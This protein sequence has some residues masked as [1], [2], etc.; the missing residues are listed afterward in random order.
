MYTVNVAIGLMVSWHL[1]CIV[2]T[3]RTAKMTK[4][5]KHYEFF[6]CNNMHVGC[7]DCFQRIADML[8]NWQTVGV[9]HSFF[10][11][12]ACTHFNCVE[13]PVMNSCFFCSIQYLFHVAKLFF[14][15]SLCCC[16]QTAMLRC[17]FHIVI[18]PCIF[19]FYLFRQLSSHSN[20]YF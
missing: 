17:F 16:M 5:R 19:S 9:R 4:K 15:P 13:S 3:Y 8:V 14:W 1:M 7:W 12:F 20:S 2:H 18:F 6:E 10:G 11:L